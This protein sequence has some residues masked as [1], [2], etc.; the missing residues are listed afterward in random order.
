MTF[1]EGQIIPEYILYPNC[2]N[3]NIDPLSCQTQT[4]TP[5]GELLKPNMGECHWAACS[6]IAGHELET[7]MYDTSGIY[8]TDANTGA[9]THKYHN[10]KCGRNSEQKGVNKRCVFLKTLILI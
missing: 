8:N 7:V 5:I 3:L 4:A 9:V 6:S 1:T 2:G 10:G